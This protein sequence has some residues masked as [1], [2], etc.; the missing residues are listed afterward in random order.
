MSKG[1]RIMARQ[2]GNESMPVEL[3]K[4]ARV[5]PKKRRN[6]IRLIRYS[7]VFTVALVMTLPLIIVHLPSQENAKQVLML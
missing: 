2:P 5:P 1:S 6:V 3:Q 7:I 4:D